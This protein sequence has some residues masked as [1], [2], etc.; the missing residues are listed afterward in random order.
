MKRSQAKYAIGRLE[1]LRCGALGDIKEAIWVI[2]KFNPILESPVQKPVTGFGSLDPRCADLIRIEHALYDLSDEIDNLLENAVC[3][4][5]RLFESLHDRHDRPASE[6][7][8]RIRKWMDAQ[9]IRLGEK[10]PK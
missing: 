3:D 9:M 4:F 2:S 8:Q 6:R 5:S 1:E 7:E 10:G